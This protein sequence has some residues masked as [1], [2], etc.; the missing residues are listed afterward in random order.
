M[1]E[2]VAHISAL[3]VYEF[4]AELGALGELIWIWDFK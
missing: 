3:M 1:Q 2:R 4:V